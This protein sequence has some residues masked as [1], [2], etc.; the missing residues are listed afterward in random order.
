MSTHDSTHA[1]FVSRGEFETAMLW[2]SERDKRLKRHER[3]F[4]LVGLVFDLAVVLLALDR[5]FG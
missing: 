5:L 3:F 1:K 2:V 4:I